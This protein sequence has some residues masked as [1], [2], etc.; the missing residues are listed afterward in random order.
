[1]R[2]LLTVL[3]S[4]TALS[5]F[6]QP[7][8]NPLNTSL[9]TNIELPE[10]GQNGN[11]CWGYTDEN[12]LEYAVMG[13]GSNTYIWS[14]EDY[15]NPIQRAA[16][17][18]TTTIW[19][20][21]KVWEDHIYVTADNTQNNLDFDGLL[22][23]DMSEAP[24]IIT[25]EFKSDIFNLGNGDEELG[26]CH[27]IY[28]DE[29]GYAYLSGCNVGNEGVLILDLADKDNPEFVGAVD[30]RYSHDVYVRDSILYSS[31]I[32]DGIFSMYDIRDRSNPILINSAQ[33]SFDFTH[34]AWLS[35]D[36]NYLFTTDELPNAYV[37]AFDISDPMDIRKIDSYR[38]IETEGQGVIPHNTHYFEG[39]LVTSWYTDGFIVLDAHRPDNLV[40]V[41]KYDTW[42]GEDGATSPREG[43]DGCWGAY[44]FFESGKM[45]A[46]DRN[47]GL[48][49]LDVDLRRACYLEGKITDAATGLPIVNTQ[50]SILGS[51]PN[52]ELSN[53]SGDYKT[54]Q[55]EEGTF[56]IEISHPNYEVA[57]AM[58]TLVSGEVTILDVQL[59]QSILSVE[60]V[61]F[62]ANNIEDA[63]LFITSD[64]GVMSEISTDENGIASIG[65]RTNE[66]YNI[67]V[68]K[69]GYLGAEVA[70][71]FFDGSTDAL[72]IT[73][74]EGYEDDFFVDLNWEVN[75]TASAGLWTRGL[76][77]ETTVQSG[78]NLLTINPGQDATGDIGD[79]AYITG[80][81][82]N[83]SW[84]DDDIDNGFTMLQSPSMNWTDGS[85]Y[86]VEFDTWYAVVM[87]NGNPVDD[88]LFVYIGNGIEEIMIH[89]E[90][91]RSS[92]WSSWSY[93]V[94]EDEIAFTENMYI[95]VRAS[96][97]GEG[98]IIEAGFDNFSAIK[99]IV[100]NTAEIDP[101]WIFTAGPNPFDER[102]T[103][104]SNDQEASQLIITDLIGRV[105][106]NQKFSSSKQINT[107]EWN[108]G[109]YLIQLRTESRFSAVRKFVKR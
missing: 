93:Q 50:I 44:P 37:D 82:S 12:G 88:S 38:P 103:I 2:I 49:I 20:D 30:T 108:S 74:G 96:D 90:T 26:S 97:E 25:W 107:K 42:Q 78:P 16:I 67:Q 86:N 104:E 58:A 39:Y 14:L 109:M 71:Y 95:R 68:A 85:S 41:A 98:N 10:G 7:D 94:F 28:I 81:A 65:L 55:V 105:I 106:I 4:F 45:L 17:P 72:T 48:Y 75:S 1:M 87:V 70:D 69:W 19:R 102:I 92:E 13:G 99:D 54:G 29:D 73:L 80:N 5:L 36:G 79:L 52:R 9:I 59:N 43:G 63:K 47:S 53:P 35:D 51:S 76:P 11:D 22:I 34:N 60:V 62:N 89:R 6:A 27:N 91:E 64:V 8:Q 77:N 15:E 100:E 18:G 101:S 66:I 40:K 3:L 31:E 83:V 57:T 33:T 21:I 56:E 84:T 23:I 61:D 24:D 46:S 32:F